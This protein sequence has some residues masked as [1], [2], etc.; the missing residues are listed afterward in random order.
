MASCL[1]AIFH[2]G[3]KGELR[4]ISL[5]AEILISNLTISLVYLKFGLN[6]FYFLRWKKR[7]L[8]RFTPCNDKKGVDAWLMLSLFYIRQRV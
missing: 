1:K 7:L 6:I 5:A 3:I 8:R 4:I 2:F